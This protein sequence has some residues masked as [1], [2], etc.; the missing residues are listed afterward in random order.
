MKTHGVARSMFVSRIWPKPWITKAPKATKF[1]VVGW[2]TK[3]FVIRGDEVK[4]G[5]GKQVN[6]IDNSEKGKRLM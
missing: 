6:E 1:G 3:K 5:S 4:S 2:D